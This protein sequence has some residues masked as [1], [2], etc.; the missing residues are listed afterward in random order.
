MLLESVANDAVSASIHWR[1]FKDLSSATAK[2]EREMSQSLTFWSLTLA[3]HDEAVL[4]RLARLYDQE[5][6]A[7]SLYRTGSAPSRPTGDCSTTE[8]SAKD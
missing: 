3:A 2:F 6:R 4:F 5:K 7:L 1:L 8:N